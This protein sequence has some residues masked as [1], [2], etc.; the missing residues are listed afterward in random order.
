MDVVGLQVAKADAAKKYAPKPTGVPMI[1]D[2]DFNTDV[3]DPTALRIALAQTR[4]GLVDLEAVILNTMGAGN[5]NAASAMLLDEERPDIPVGTYQGDTTG[6]PSV[7]TATVGASWSAV[8]REY[9]ATQTSGFESAL[10]IARRVMAA[11]TK[12]DLLYVSVGFL[13]NLQTILQSPADD[14]SPLTGMQLFQ[15][16]VKSVFMMAG[17]Y[18]GTSP[19]TV[20]ETNFATVPAASNYV[21]NACPVP[22]YLL[23]TEIGAP[24]ILGQVLQAFETGDPLRRM[25][26]VAGRLAI[27]RAGYDPV[28]VYAASQ[29]SL[30]AAG[31]NQ[32]RGTVSVDPSTGL[33][34][35]TPNSTGNHYWAVRQQGSNTALAA[36]YVPPLTALL[37]PGW[38]PAPP[39]GTVPRP[40]TRRRT[41][42]TPAQLGTAPVVWL[43]GDDLGAVASA[44]SSWTGAIG[45]A[46]SA[47]QAT[48]ANQPTVALGW[49]EL[50][51]ARFN[52]TANFLDVLDPAVQLAYPR[53]YVIATTSKASGG[54]D[55]ALAGVPVQANASPFWRFGL[56]IDTT[57]FAKPYSNGG[58]WTAGPVVRSWSNPRVV[59]LAT[60]ARRLVI[61]GRPEGSPT[62]APAAGTYPDATAQPFRIGANATPGNYLQ[63]DVYEVL[64]LDDTKIT[65]T[66]RGLLRDYFRDKYLIGV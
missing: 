45:G 65:V 50:L 60:A 26:E 3:D 21:M 55:Q 47:A 31:F 22:I 48:G 59:E 54:G 42:F 32:V 51:V 46:L 63:G 33:H 24:M 12:A 5:A 27:G 58:V 36:A 57:L 19:A 66:E 44:V 35:W 25:Y 20:T 30:T 6:L 1:L 23:G 38:E 7:V 4:R 62:N 8:A 37:S 18:T 10:R 28:T 52:G 40:L 29:G 53:L 9:P 43:R 14:L 56:T 17:N 39:T 64:L 16:S 15:Q 2:S 11:R 61:D 49:H 13:N 34:S 41:R